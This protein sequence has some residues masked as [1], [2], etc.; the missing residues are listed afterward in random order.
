MQFEV[1]NIVGKVVYKDRFVATE[2]NINKE[3]NLRDIV[4]GVY[5]LKISTVDE[6]ISICFI[7]KK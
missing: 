3:I 7:V 5:F 6:N 2:G 1:I 4:G